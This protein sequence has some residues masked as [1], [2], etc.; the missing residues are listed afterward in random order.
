MVR[1]RALG[2]ILSRH[3]RSGMME[4]RCDPA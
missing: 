4:R 1:N 2:K 3:H